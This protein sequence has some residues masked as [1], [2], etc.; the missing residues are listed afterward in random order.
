MISS[1]IAL[2]LLRRLPFSRFSFPRWKS[3]LAITLVA[4]VYALVPDPSVDHEGVCEPRAALWRTVVTIVATQ[5]A[6]FLTTYVVL[7]WWLR[8][9]DRWD[10]RGNYF[11]LLAAAWLVADLAMAYLPVFG[12]RSDGILALLAI[13]SV[14]VTINAT[15]GVM[16]RVGVPYIAVGV[17]IGA[18][19]MLLLGT[20]VMDIF[21][22]LLMGDED[23]W[24]EDGQGADG[25]AACPGCKDGLWPHP[26]ASVVHI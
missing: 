16:P 13:H 15:K 10:G 6:F 1:A 18:V 2:F 4:F 11:N 12:I 3:V 22:E 19:C 23:G 21:D 7:C 17:A 25:E 26:A 14:V 24:F 8:R 20:Q 5:W 9:R